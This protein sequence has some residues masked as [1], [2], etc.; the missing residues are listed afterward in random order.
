[1]PGPAGPR[2]TGCCLAVVLGLGLLSK[3]AI[4]FLYVPAALL[5]VTTRQG[6]V[7][8]RTPWPYLSFA[9][10]LLFFLPVVVWNSHHG[11]VMFRHDLGHTR[12]AQGWG[13]SSEA[14]LA[15]VGGQLGVITP[16]VAVLI[17]YLLITVP[18]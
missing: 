7:R 9:L 5:L 10:S 11:W 18:A 13:I 14:L 8:L 12:L 15:F 1:M 2:P 6:R 16:I 17:L 4:A 3:Y